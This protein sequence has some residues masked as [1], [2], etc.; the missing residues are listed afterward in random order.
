MVA[1]DSYYRQTAKLLE[2]KFQRD[3]S[4]RLAFMILSQSFG[5][6]RNDLIM[7]KSCRVDEV[8][9]TNMV[10]RLLKDEPIQ[11]VLD[12]AWFDGLRLKVTTDTLIPRP[13]TEELVEWVFEEEKNRVWSSILDIGTGTGCIPL[14]L[15]SRMP[16]ANIEAV[17]ISEGAIAVARENSKNLGL[18]VKFQILDILNDT[19]EDNTYD[20][21]VSNPPYIRPSEQDQMHANVL[22]Y[23]PSHALFIPEEKPLLFYERIAILGTIA[24]KH[25]GSL[26]FEINEAFGSECEMLLK[27]LGYRQVE[28]RKDMQ[29][30]DRMLRAVYLKS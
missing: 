30:K 15:K 5:I 7:N 26:Y 27:N 3:E 17:D 25:K 6:T 11:Y 28:L 1:I 10:Q 8:V 22:D 24:L 12:E 29:G 23:E 4:R 18:E 16:N 2:V 21:L 19:L 20:V 14:A 9:I 13:E